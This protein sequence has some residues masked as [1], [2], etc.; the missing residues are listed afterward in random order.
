MTERP[1]FGIELH[2]EQQRLA[3]N[4]VYT[5]L[6]NREDPI[7]WRTM[8]IQM[9]SILGSTNPERLPATANLSDATTFVEEMTRGTYMENL[10]P[11]ILY[12]LGYKEIEDGGH[13]DTLIISPRHSPDDL[14]W[15]LA[16]ELSAEGQQIGVFIPVGHY[17]DHEPRIL[18][19]RKLFHDVDNVV[20]I[21]STQYMN[22]GSVSVFVETLNLLRNED[23]ASRVKNVSVVI[24]MFAGSRGHKLGQAPEI[25]Y[26]VLQSKSIPA[27]FSLDV[28]DVLDEL[29]ENAP[30]VQFYSVDIHNEEYPNE[31]FVRRGFEFKSISPEDSFAHA[32]V[33][34]IKEQKLQELPL[35]LIAV[36]RG[37]VLRTEKLAIEILKLQSNGYHFIDVVEVKKTRNTAGQ[38]E[39]AS[40]EK[41]VRISE[42][43]GEVIKS[44]IQMTPQELEQFFIRVTDDDMLDSGRS[45]KTDDELIDKLMPNPKLKMTVVSHAVM[46]EG[47]RSALDNTGSD[48]VIVGNT[49]TNSDLYKDSRGRV[50]VVDLSA[51]IAKAINKRK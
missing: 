1:Q 48:V 51:D 37:A 14:F 38:V 21:G 26:E 50:R 42:E 44:E 12:A 17:A 43:K 5:G 31:E 10:T 15:K 23:F 34:E 39:S 33:R 29:G 25:G 40:V 32:V 49:L 3:T 30:T 35:R 27:R 20:L 16:D 45:A 24:P 41:I 8:A 36:D 46:S 47:V 19:P 7:T 4:G 28:R 11:E 2:T 18:S 6:H 9:R 22:G 13:L